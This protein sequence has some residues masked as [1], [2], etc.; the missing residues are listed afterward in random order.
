MSRIEVLPFG[1]DHLDGAAHLLARRHRRQLIHEPLLDPAYAE[2][3][4][5]KGE[6]A[7]CFAVEGSSGAIALRN[8]DLVGYVLGA[9]RPGTLWGPNVWV[10]AAGHALA[11]GTDAEVARDLYAA[12]A[13]PWV[14]ADLT[15]HYA[16]LPSHDT[17]LL[18]A[19]FRSG[20]GAQHV[21]AVRDLGEAVE[22]AKT[23][24]FTV[25]RA[26]HRDVAALA[27]LDL[28]LD[29][30]QFGSP[31][32]SGVPAPPLA[33]AV[34]DW[35]QGIDDPSLATFVAVLDDHVVGSAI[36]VSATKSSMHTGI[37]R[38]DHAAHLGF[39][40]VLPEARGRR[41]GQALGQAVLAWA[42]AQGYR[43][44][45]TDWRATNLLSSRTW[46]KLGW[47]PTFLR[48]HRTITP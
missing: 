15:Q 27:A 10:E 2:P 14:D 38:P 17:A 5:A 29:D 42:S 1:E 25:R 41:I 45:A 36:G 3:T 11:D 9:P 32:F 39:A 35:E 48:V 44:C 13:G 22:P 43:S 34:A 21:H 7:A 47:R 46:P 16:I 12:A 26:E 6:L 40:A 8:G 20:F 24:G 19:W 23:H 18:D 30:H 31:V 33:E 28:V 37:A 4:A